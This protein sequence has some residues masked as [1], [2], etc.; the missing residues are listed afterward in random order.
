MTHLWSVAKPNEKN[1]AAITLNVFRIYL[2]TRFVPQQRASVCCNLD[3]S[4]RL[5]R[6]S[7][8]PAVVGSS[9][10]QIGLPN[11]HSS[12]VK[13]MFLRVFMLLIAR[14]FRRQLQ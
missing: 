7:G 1:I 11:K 3:H 14:P 2:F 6:I 5:Q 4:T 9:D 12:R 10:D 13:A 8:K